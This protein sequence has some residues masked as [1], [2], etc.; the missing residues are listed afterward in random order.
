MLLGFHDGLLNRLAVRPAAVSL[1][2]CL[3]L[4]HCPF[5]GLLVLGW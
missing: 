3:R 1:L 4:V 2:A 5:E